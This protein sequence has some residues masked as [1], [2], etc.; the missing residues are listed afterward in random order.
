MTVDRPLLLLA[1]VLAAACPNVPAED[2]FTLTGSLERDAV[3]GGSTTAVAIEFGSKNAR[4][5][6]WSCDLRM[7]A[8]ACV[9]EHHVNLYLALPSITDFDGLGHPG[10]VGGDGQPYGAYELLAQKTG[11]GEPITIP[12]DAT[13]LALVA[14]DVDGDGAADLADDVETTAASRL[15]DGSVEVLHIGSFD[16]PLSLRITGTTGNGNAVT[17]EFAGP[18]SPVPNPP[19]LDV[20]RTCVAADALP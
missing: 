15:M 10:C 14:S 16:D 19:P 3:G 6:W 12:G 20:A 9:G 13:V 7:T 17:A 8:N 11:D 4:A 18:T 5:E 1:A 2:S